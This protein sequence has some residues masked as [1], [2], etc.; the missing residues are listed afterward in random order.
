MTR[1]NQD[2]ESIIQDIL[3]T[4]VGNIAHHVTASIIDVT[5]S[6][7]NTLH[8]YE[9]TS[10]TA[11]KLAQDMLLSYREGLIRAFSLSLSDFPGTFEVEDSEDNS[12]RIRVNT[13]II[14]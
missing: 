9:I 1:K 12:Y 13:R 8:E 3:S 10:Q 11:K 5:D 2:A 6:E 4:P 7:G 14:Y